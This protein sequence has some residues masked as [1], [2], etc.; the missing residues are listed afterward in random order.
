MVRQ[1]LALALTAF[2]LTGCLKDKM[3]FHV[4]GD[5]S[6][7]IKRTSWKLKSEL[8]DPVKTWKELESDEDRANYIVDTSEQAGVSWTDH[9]GRVDGE[10]IIVTSTGYTRDVGKYAQV[11]TNAKTKETEKPVS[12]VVKKDGDKRTLELIF[13]QSKKAGPGGEAPKMTEEQKKQRLAMMKKMMGSMLKGL[14]LTFEFHLPG[15]ITKVSGFKKLSADSCRL[16]IDEKSFWDFVPDNADGKM[17]CSVSW[18][19]KGAAPTGFD[20]KAKAAEE[21]W[22]K[23]VEEVEAWQKAWLEKALAED[24]E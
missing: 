15:K 19:N 22:P 17:V 6:A 5:G 3:V 11:K 9:V 2:A 1:T 18:T 13:D 16:V 20:A 4:H 12:I 10:S 21:S 7:T 23:R 24:D 8:S 14:E